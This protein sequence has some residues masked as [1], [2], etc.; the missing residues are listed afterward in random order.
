MFG[1]DQGD[2]TTA[3]IDVLAYMDYAGVDM[4]KWALV[5]LSMYAIFRMVFYFTLLFKGTHR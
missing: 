2:C 5:L 4:W 3:G 1:P